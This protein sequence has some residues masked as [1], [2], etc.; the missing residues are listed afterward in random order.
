MDPVF[1]LQWSEFL[2][3]HRLQQFFPK[4]QGYSVLIPLS[5]QEKAIDLVLMQRAKD[6]HRVVTVQVKA[7][8]T[9]SHKPPKRATTRRFHFYTWFKRFKIQDDADFYLLFGLYA[10]DTSRTKRVTKSWYLDCTL[11]FTREEMIKLLLDCKTVKGQPDSMFGFG[12]DTPERIFQT[13]GVSDRSLPDFSKYLFEKR[14]SLIR[15]K[16]GKGCSVGY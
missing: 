7:S 3:A 9:Y 12:F 6:H 1:T 5:R 2:L 14:I 4:K 16:L 15:R 11:L 13:R 10:P 8:R